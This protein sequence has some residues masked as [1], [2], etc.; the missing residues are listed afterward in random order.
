MQGKKNP[1]TNI[2]AQLLILVELS[3]LELNLI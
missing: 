2:N 3:F 1:S